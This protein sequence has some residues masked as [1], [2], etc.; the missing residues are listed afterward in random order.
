VDDAARAYYQR[1]A[2]EYDD[3]WLGTGLFAERDRPGWDVERDELCALLAS[4]PPARTLDVACG[5]GFL[6]RHLPGLVV[7]IDQSASMVAIAQARLPHGVALT[8]DA[9][10]LP[11]ADGAF[12]RLH[13]AH[14]LG[15]LEGADRERFL[16]EARRVAREVVVVD[17]ALR[18]GVAP[19]ERQERVLGDGSRHEVYKRYFTAEEL[20]RELG[21]GQ[22]LYDGRWFVCAQS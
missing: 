12:E 1:R 2:P 4:L 6:T 13:A 5:T 20:L 8:G 9:L 16:A 14:F 18:D 22:A 19:E 15:H 11:F 3:W 10:A 7:G 17:S 21:G